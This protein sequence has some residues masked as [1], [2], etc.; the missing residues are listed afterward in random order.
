[1]SVKE[2][3]CGRPWVRRKLDILMEGILVG[4]AELEQYISKIQL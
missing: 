4:L 1:M 3:G 2:A